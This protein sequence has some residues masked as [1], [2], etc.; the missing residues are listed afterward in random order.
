VLYG[1][2]SFRICAERKGD[3]IMSDAVAA[4]S[5]PAVRTNRHTAIC[6]AV[7]ELLGE[8]GYDRMSMDAVAARARAS[9]ATI[10]RAWPNK[11][12][13]VTE[14]LRHKFGT[15]PEP[16]DTGSLRGDLMALMN[17][18][19]QAANSPDG[20]VIA[21][22]MSAAAR[23]PELAQ[24]LFSCVLEAKHVMYAAIISRAVER[25]EVPPGTDPNVLQE[26]MH[27]MV[28]TQKL[29]SEKPMDHEFV[30]HVVDDVLI[31]VLC[32]EKDT[33]TG[34]QTQAPREIEAPTR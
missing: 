14:A 10:Y 1:T 19:C 24:T 27:A 9:K 20:D 28:F 32:H 16:P 22:L 11:P 30:V 26:V 7:F 13:L 25:G 21:G 23:T 34:T 15:T 29:W 8:V 5:T 18:A 3:A 2:V 6:S 12:D 33:G 17:F 31:P 4:S